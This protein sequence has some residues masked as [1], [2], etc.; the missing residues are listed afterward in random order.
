M[1]P[2][3]AA[4][5]KRVAKLR[6]SNLRVRHCAKEFTLRWIRPL[7]HREKLAYECP[8]LTDPSHEP[9]AGRVFNFAFNC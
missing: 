1:T 2:C 7:G 4:L 3:L 9:A 8:L 6:D 5:V